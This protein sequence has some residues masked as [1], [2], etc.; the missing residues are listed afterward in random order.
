MNHKVDPIHLDICWVPVMH[1]ALLEITRKGKMWLWWPGHLQFYGKHKHTTR[2]TQGGKHPISFLNQV[3]QE[4]RG[5]SQESR[6]L[7]GVFCWRVTPNFRGNEGGGTTYCFLPGEWKTKSLDA[8][9]T[10]FSSFPQF[11][12][13]DLLGQTLPV[14][15][16][17]PRAFL[18]RKRSGRSKRHVCLVPHPQT[19][20]S[21]ARP[22]WVL[23]GAE[24]RI[25]PMTPQWVWEQYPH[26]TNWDVC[27]ASNKESGIQ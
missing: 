11:I 4:H 20:D 19:S 6:N 8:V 26:S 7:K 22:S 15:R 10:C 9:S 21:K 13:L 16:S 24:V 14:W 18:R 23:P 5:Y 27:I 12:T 2:I 1:W 25:I 3:P 17:I